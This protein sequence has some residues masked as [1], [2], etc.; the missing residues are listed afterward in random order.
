MAEMRDHDRLNESM[1]YL[2]G[3]IVAFQAVLDGLEA[4]SAADP[5]VAEKLSGPLI[6]AR[7]AML[8]AQTNAERT[9]AVRAERW[10]QSPPDPKLR[11]PHR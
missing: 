1:D 10:Q 9:R 6:Q 3:L 5:A 4:L 11:D 2:G 8:S 7:A